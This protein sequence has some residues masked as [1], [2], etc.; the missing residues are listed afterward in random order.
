MTYKARREPTEGSP[1]SLNLS[2]GAPFLCLLEEGAGNFACVDRG[3][4]GSGVW[5][6]QILAHGRKAFSVIFAF[7]RRFPSSPESSGCLRGIF[8]V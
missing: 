8:H 3:L 7:A 2:E 5:G 1:E 6:G 4:V